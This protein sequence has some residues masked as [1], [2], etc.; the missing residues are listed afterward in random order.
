MRAGRRLAI[1]ALA[2]P[3]AVMSCAAGPPAGIERFDAAITV[4]I[5]GSVDVQEQLHVQLTGSADSFRRYTPV[6]RHDGVFDVHGSMDGKPFPRGE[7][8]NELK[9]AGGPALD[10]VW[11]FTPVAA[12]SHLFTLQYRAAGAVEV[13]GIRGLLSWRAFQAGQNWS[14]KEAH[15]TVT[16]PHGAVLLDDPWV[17]EAG[18]DVVRRVDGLEASR[19]DVGNRESA[20]PGVSFTIDTMAAGEPSWQYF[21]GRTG[22]LMP[23]FVATGLCVLVIA[24]G[25]IALIRF[26][27]PALRERPDAVTPSVP[28]KL[29]E[30][31]V[32]GR[33]YGYALDNLI[34]AG[35]IDR[36]RV[37]VARDLRRA[38]IATIIFGA[39]AWVFTARW[40]DHFG[41][42][43]HAIPLSILC[44][45]IL[46]LIEARRFS[47]LSQM[48]LN[49][50]ERMLYSARVPDGPTSA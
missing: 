34:E 27:L 1:G 10:A 23:A 18:W 2:A 31:L 41:P 37:F 14:I 44:G 43:P 5:D 22:D 29:S 21:E 40:L 36:E 16:L 6:L 45:G 7:G 15:L 11:Q 49:A 12:G 39:A 4:L 25:V 38:G 13:S 9:V 28:A 32:R 3:L 19:R 35:L 24:A 50:R 33:P 20:T 48:G 30:A 47:L 17:D 46:F 8:V 42:W 26:R